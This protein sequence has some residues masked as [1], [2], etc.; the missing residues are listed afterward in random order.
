MEG[1]FSTSCSLWMEGPL[2][3]RVIAERMGTSAPF[4]DEVKLAFDRHI[5]AVLESIDDGFIS[6]NPHWCCTYMNRAAERILHKKRD[7]LLGKNIWEVFPEVV[8]TVFW[9]KCYEAADTQTITH[10]ED[11]YPPTGT[12]F[13]LRISPSEAGVAVSFHKMTER[14][15]RVEDRP[16]YE[17]RAQLQASLMELAYD[18]I[19]GRDPASVIV[20]WNRGAKQL[21]GWTTQEAIGNVT[22]ELLQTRFPESREA[23]DRFLATGEQWEGE[24][25]HTCKD[26]TQVIVESRQVV[27]RDA[28]TDDRRLYHR[29][30]YQGTQARRST[31]AFSH[32]GQ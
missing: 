5:Q 8:G 13:S 29:T 4:P 16:S 25:V 6:V 14:H 10:V 12:W 27:T 21:Y 9:K 23:L 19:I 3:R 2:E 15:L 18:A 1:G 24:L 11:V 28:R 20:T 17:Q 32:R 7:D 26:G 30:Q 22:H 31:R